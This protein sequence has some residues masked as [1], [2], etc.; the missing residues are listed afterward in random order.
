MI[1]IGY[2]KLKNASP[3]VVFV[4]ERFFLRIRMNENELRISSSPDRFTHIAWLLSYD[5][6]KCSECSMV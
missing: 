4:R 1:S 2:K 3:P 5:V 6:K